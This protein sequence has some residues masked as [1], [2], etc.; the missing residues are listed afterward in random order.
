MYTKKLLLVFLILPIVFLLAWNLYLEYELKS[1]KT[2]VVRMTGYDPKSLLSGHYLY[3]RPVWGETDC[4]QFTDAHC[5]TE[6]F[7]A[8]YRYYLPEF[9]AQ[10]LDRQLLSADL[11]VDMV[12]ILRGRAKPFV[13]DLLIE[14]KPWKQWIMQ[15]AK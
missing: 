3:L 10:N 6:L 12:F 14:D 2:V 5:P 13:K 4:S 8:V 7:S 15:S 1:E 9:D 11:K